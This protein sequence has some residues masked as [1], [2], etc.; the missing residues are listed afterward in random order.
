MSEFEVNTGLVERGR[1]AVADLVRGDGDA[2][3]LAVGVEL[4]GDEPAGERTFSAVVGKDIAVLLLRKRSGQRWEQRDGADAGGSLR[5]LDLGRR[6]G[7]VDAAADVDP[8]L[9]PVDILVTKALGLAAAAAGIID[10]EGE[11][12]EVVVQVV[13]DLLDLI[14]GRRVA[15]LLRKVL[16]EKNCLRSVKRDVTFALGFIQDLP[17]DLALG[18]NSLLCVGLGKL[19]DVRLNLFACDRGDILRAKL[20]DGALIGRGIIAQGIRRKR[21]LDLVPPGVGDVGE[22]DG[23]RLLGFS[24]VCLDLV[25]DL[26]VCL[27]AK[28]FAL[29]VDCDDGFMQAVR[30]DVVFGI[31]IVKPPR[32]P[33]RRW[34]GAVLFMCESSRSMG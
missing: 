22:R 4:V 3:A 31:G 29:A 34:A 30:P 17:D 26:A 12:A 5:L 10:Q 24:A 11:Q 20:R 32:I 19:V 8:A 21:W 18:D 13:L 2:R 27:S 23:L 33:L 6:T 28:R 25:P 9:L 14:S 15:A 7:M 1:V 16:R